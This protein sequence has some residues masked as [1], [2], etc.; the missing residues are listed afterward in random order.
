M[1]QI[2]LAAV[3]Y[4]QDYD[5]SLFE[6][7]PGAFGNPMDSTKYT[8]WEFVVQP[9]LKNT[10]VFRCPSSSAGVVDVSYAGRGTG[11]IGAN[12]LLGYLYN[13]WYYTHG[14]D[15]NPPTVARPVN[16]ALIAYPAITVFAA[17]SYYDPAYTRSY[18]VDPSYGKGQA[19]GLADRHTLGSNLA[20]M[21]G[22]A[23]WYR[24]DSV[25]SQKAYDDNIAATTDA[26][27]AQV[28]EETNYN[29]AGL[30][31]DV[32]ADNMQTNPGKDPTGCCNY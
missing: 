28:L 15:T 27:V 19:R 5:G 11:S 12:R 25:L 26:E 22:H 21:D 9:Y 2:G 14:G 3:Q 13:Y 1:K 10:A 17:D 23:K 20:F 6:T 24:T 7:T 29:A 32:D 4:Q 31:W 18:Y 8:T 16:D 30:I